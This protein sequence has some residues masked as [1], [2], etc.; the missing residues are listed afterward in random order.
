MSFLGTLGLF[1][2][3]ANTV[4]AA[5]GCMMCDA[6]L[7]TAITGVCTAPDGTAVVADR[8]Y[9]VKDGMEHDCD[10]FND[11]FNCW[12][13]GGGTYTLAVDN[14]G[15]HWEWDLHVKDNGCHVEPLTYNPV[16]DPGTAN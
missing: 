12:E 8:V 5:A 11:S 1:F 16:L 15:N 10:Y 4:P 14:G 3:V 7:R 9:V 6:S 2:A 13:L